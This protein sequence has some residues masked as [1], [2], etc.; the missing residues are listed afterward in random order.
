MA[1]KKNMNMKAIE[2]L[3]LAQ[4]LFWLMQEIL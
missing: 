1:S 3:V 2:M 4:A